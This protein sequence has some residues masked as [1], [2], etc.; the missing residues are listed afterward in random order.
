MKGAG[1]LSIALTQI[2]RPMVISLLISVVVR[3]STNKIACFS[4]DVIGPAFKGVA[5]SF[6]HAAEEEQA[7]EGKTGNYGETD[8]VRLGSVM[9][10]EVG[11]LEGE[12]AGHKSYG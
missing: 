9:L 8:P 3:I 10:H 12:V 6:Q 4:R 7:D 1:K 2:S 5:Y 11:N